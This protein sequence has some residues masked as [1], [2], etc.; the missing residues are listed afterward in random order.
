[1]KIS[2]FANVSLPT[3]KARGIQI[4]K[5][6]EALGEISDLELIIPTKLES[7]KEDIFK[8]YNIKKTFKIR[9]IPFLNLRIFSKHG[10][11]SKV[12]SFIFGIFATI[13]LFFR[14]P[15]VIYTRDHYCAYFMSFFKK[16][17]YEIHNIPEYNP[18]MY[19]SMFEKL[20]GVICI[21]KA[22]EED[23]SK[24][25]KIKKTT[26][27]PDGFDPDMFSGPDVDLHEMLNLSPNVT[28]VTYTGH[29]LPWKGVDTLVASAKYLTKSLHILIVGGT[30]DKINEYRENCKEMDNVTIYG[31]VK[32]EQ[33]GGIL[34]SSDILVIPNSG[35]EKISYRYTSPIKLFEYMG[36]GKPIIASNL[37]S[38]REIL[39]EEN[40]FFFK[41]DDDKDLAKVIMT[42]AKQKE[43][44]IKKSS[45]SLE[46][47]SQYFWNSR[48]NG[49]LK[50]IGRDK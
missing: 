26:V 28:I 2:Y 11:G 43:L 14:N 15:D 41:A 39:N 13:S 23:I 19:L 33:V 32:H 40:A 7:E 44:A 50:F 42:V 10:I 24:I 4:A 31:R 38:I 20:E 12:G 22:L 27:I 30:D 49:I 47:S 46:N 34:K 3:E 8:Y 1:M 37:P 6:C 35:R 18:K 29:L 17:F 9:R 48:A 45:Q 25:T 16:V 21:T 36:S 5:T